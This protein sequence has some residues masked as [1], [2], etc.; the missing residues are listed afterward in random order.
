VR[1]ALFVLLG[2]ALLAGCGL[3][4]DT[5]PG[6]VLAR[7]AD[8]LGEIRSAERL[9]LNVLVE[10]ADG[11]PFGFRLDGPFALCSENQAL[12]TLDVE[13]TQVA[14]GNEAS[15]RLV[16]TGEQGYVV[17]GGTAYELDEQQGAD[18]R[19]ACDE[20][21]G[22]G[23]E[24]LEVGDWVVD[25]DGSSGG[26][27]DTVTGDLDVVAVVNDLVDVARAF[28]GSALTRLDGDD[29]QRIAEATD[30][31]SFELESGADDG[32]LRRLF[33]EAELGFD[34]PEDLRRS[35]GDAVGATF[36]FELELEG[37]NET[38]RVE[39]PANPRPSS[40]L[41]GG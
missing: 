32:L 23:L 20:L 11:D 9:A 22:A 24:R 2:V 25:P 7:T 26:D 31:S 40:E 34:V 36:T 33:L 8:S 16:S 4:D 3:G 5:D 14:N 39:A 37:P 21:D 27:V 41:P 19:A 15:V 13:Y 28:S 30:E 1:R 12:P 38:V 6:A 17:V 29:A 18:L 35:L 10:P